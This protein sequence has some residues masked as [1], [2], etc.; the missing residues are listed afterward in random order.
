MYIH[1]ASYPISVL[2]PSLPRQ[3]WGSPT[4]WPGWTKPQ[5]G[6][7]HWVLNHWAKAKWPLKELDWEGKLSKTGACFSQSGLPRGTAEFKLATSPLHPKWDHK[8]HCR[9]SSPW[10]PSIMQHKWK[11]NMWNHY[12]SH[13][14]P[15]TYAIIRVWSCPEVAMCVSWSCGSSHQLASTAGASQAPFEMDQWLPSA[16]GSRRLN[17]A[18][19]K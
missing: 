16:N 1:G 13:K 9:V 3:S 8:K 5:Q 11:Y 17:N 10:I 6:T 14:L 2:Q 4:L 15:P 12:S 19:C 7:S 18:P